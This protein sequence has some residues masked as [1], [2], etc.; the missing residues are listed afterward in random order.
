M[1]EK[2]FR[3]QTNTDGNDTQ[4]IV[5]LEQDYD[6]LEILSLKIQ[7][8]KLYRT[9]TSDYGVLVGRVIANEGLGVPNAKISVFIPLSLDDQSDPVISNIYP[10][11]T[12]TD[13]TSLG[14]RYNLITPRENVQ[15]GTFPTKQ[16]FLDNDVYLEVYEKYYKFTTVTNQSGDY[17]IFGVPTGQQFVHLDVDLSDIGAYSSTADVMVANG[18]PK[19]LFN[20]VG[21][22]YTFKGGTSLEQLPQYISQTLA[23]N[24]IPLWG[25]LSDTTQIGITRVDFKINIQINPV[26]YFTFAVGWDT[27]HLANGYYYSNPIT[28]ANGGG[29]KAPGALQYLIPNYSQMLVKAYKYDKDGNELPFDDTAYKLV[30]TADDLN[31]GIYNLILPCDLDKVVTDEHG[32]IV[33]SNNDNGIGTTGKWRIEVYNNSPSSA[34]ISNFL[35]QKEGNNGEPFKLR[36]GRIYSVKTAMYLAYTLR[37]DGNRNLIQSLA[38]EPILNSGDWLNGF[39]YFGY[40]RFDKT[41]G[42]YPAWLHFA[43]EF[44]NIESRVIDVT[45]YIDYL[46]SPNI[47][48][49]NANLFYYAVYSFKSFSDNDFPVGLIQNII[50]SNTTY[51][52]SFSSFEPGRATAANGNYVFLKSLHGDCYASIKNYIGQ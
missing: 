31:Q 35:I 26:A 29:N 11:T 48:N 51:G 9:F 4:L 49:N 40:G 44:Y 37:D 19:S 24:V 21:T 46:I 41:G 3:I 8:D 6:C 20:S 38:A 2:S 7:Q 12:I 45:D 52:D 27:Q 17:M 47:G 50:N 34:G 13:K 43:N 14:V 30:S 36:A 22:N 5:K 23:C 10:F 15:A 1:S 33:P 25:D 39:L 32:N 42:D 16:Q 18:V 28:F